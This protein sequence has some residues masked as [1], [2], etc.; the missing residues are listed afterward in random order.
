M[1]HGNATK[2]DDLNTPRRRVFR[3]GLIAVALLCLASPSFAESCGLLWRVDSGE[4]A[5][6]HVFGTIHSEDP[7]VV[8][9][10]GPVKEAFRSADTYA[11]EMIP[12]FQA[13]TELT[14][15]MHFQD[16][17]NLRE[18]L[19]EDLFR[20]VTDALSKRGVG[21]GLALKMKPWAVAVTLSFPQPETGMFLDIMLFN[22]ALAAGKR[23]VGLEEATEQLAFFT[24]LSMED[25]IELLEATLKHQPEIDESMEELVQAWLSRDPGALS[26]LSDTYLEDLPGGLADRFRKQVI[27]R[28][29][30]RMYEAAQPLVAEGNAF[31]AVGALHLYGDEGLL[32]FFRQEGREVSCVY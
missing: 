23:A 1:P 3:D 30:H 22:R 14:R 5:A 9:L 15:A 26:D 21:E 27:D 29:N 28:R 2:T 20:R 19:G 25:Q 32:E 16:Q 4:S 24:G 13:I 7:R 11:M 31:I 17:G 8:D 6:S 18:V 12:D 10:P